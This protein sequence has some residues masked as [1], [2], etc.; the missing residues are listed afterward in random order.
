V[1]FLVYYAFFITGAVGVFKKSIIAAEKGIHAPLLIPT[2]ISII[3]FVVIKAVL[4]DEG[5]HPLAFMMVG[6]A[7][8]LIYQT[9]LE[10]KKKQ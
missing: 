8:G 3:N 5:N 2:T 6:M 10:E 1:G 9:T 4:A 7:V